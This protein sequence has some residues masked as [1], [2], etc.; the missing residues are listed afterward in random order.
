MLLLLLCSVSNL[1]NNL[2][3]AST[4]SARVEPAVIKGQPLQGLEANIDLF[5]VVEVVV[6]I[7]TR[8]VGRIF[9]KLLSWPINVLLD[10]NNNTTSD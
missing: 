6:V 4:V 10:N 9:A 3:F 5:L 8:R 7:I 2:S 1:S